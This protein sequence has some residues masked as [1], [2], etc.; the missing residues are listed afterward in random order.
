MAHAARNCYHR[1]DQNYT[2]ATLL[3][4]MQNQQTRLPSGRNA[5]MEA[6]IT[7]PET[8]YDSN[9]YLDS[10]ACTHITNTTTNLQ[11][12][13][14]CDRAEKVYVSNGQGNQGKTTQGYIKRW[15]VLL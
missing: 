11:N 9:W 14:P 5:P 8:L 6:M 2:E 4:S 7:T 12:Q 10:G 13:Q 1:Y 15:I 3:Q